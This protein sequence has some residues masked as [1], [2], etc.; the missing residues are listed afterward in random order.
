MET[1]IGEPYKEQLFTKTNRLTRKMGLYNADNEEIIPPIYDEIFSGFVNPHYVVV[2]ENGQYGLFDLKG[3]RIFESIYNGFVLAPA[4]SSIISA[5][6]FSKENWVLLKTNGERVFPEA[7]S[8]IIQLQ[9][10]F[11]VLQKEDLSSALANISGEPITGFDFSS[12]GGLNENS[13]DA[14]WYE[15]NDVVAS[16]T[17][18]LETIFINSKGEVVKR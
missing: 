18:G 9:K 12:M 4:D 2:V 17:S 5:Y 7:Y 6:Q 14:E 16:A 11:V 13:P 3:N 15:E 1:I 8:K 10:G